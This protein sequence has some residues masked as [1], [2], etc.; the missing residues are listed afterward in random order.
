MPVILLLCASVI[1]GCAWWP[2][3]EF[4]AQGI[5]SIPLIM[6]AYGTSGL[7][8]LPRMLRQYNAWKAQQP[9][10]FLIFLIGGYANLA[11]AASMIYGEVVRSM[12]LFYTL[13]IWG[14]LGGRIFLKEKIDAQ[15]ACAVALAVAG[16]FFLLGGMKIFTTPP[17]WIDLLAISSGFAFSMNNLC[18]RATQSVP[19]SSKVSAM[20]LGCA[21]FAAILL[22]SGVQAFPSIAAS[23][24]LLPIGFGFVVLTATLGTQWGVTKLEVGRASVLIVMELIVSVLTASVFAGETMAPLEWFGGAMIL[25]AALLEAWR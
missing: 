20:F 4:S 21:C 2:L 1:W 11:F 9:L 8:L 15:R 14:V 25:A 16:A 12:A 24:W 23:D 22:L 13:P 19:L 10:L 7:F 5:A 3:K 17:S 18:F 6:V